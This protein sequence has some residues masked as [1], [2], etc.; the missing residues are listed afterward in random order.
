MRVLLH[1]LPVS[2]FGL[3]LSVLAENNGKAFATAAASGAG[4]VSSDTPT[5]M[6]W[7]LPLLGTQLDS[8]VVMVCT[9]MGWLCRDVLSGSTAKQRRCIAPDSPT[10][11]LVVL[12][13]GPSIVSI[14][15]LTVLES[16]L[17]PKSFVDAS[18]SLQNLPTKSF[19]PTTTV[20]IGCSLAFCVPKLRVVEPARK[21]TTA[22]YDLPPT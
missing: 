9:D 16:T 10:T 22:E 18:A 3:P 19:L 20:Q 8:S 4:G 2:V 7:V 14:I 1:M 17:K 11:K 15:A 21:P 13:E 5:I 6:T 12:P